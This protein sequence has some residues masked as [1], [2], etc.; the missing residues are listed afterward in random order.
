VYAISHFN[1]QR[2]DH[3]R[4]LFLFD[5]GL[6]ISAE[7]IQWLKVHLANCADFQ[8]ISK[9]PWSERITWADTNRERIESTARDPQATVTWW[10]E[11][12]AP[13]SLVAACIELAAA[14]EVGPSYI[15][16]LPVCL[17]GS[18]SGVQHLAMMMRDE[19]A[20]EHV[21]LV[22][23]DE[24]RDIYQ[25]ITDRVVERLKASGDEWADWWLWWT[26]IKRK[27]IKRPAMT[28][29]YSVTPYG[30]AQQ[31]IEAH[32]ELRADSNWPT[33]VAA[34]YLAKHIMAVSEE[35]L[36]RPAAAMKFI[37]KLA[38][39]CADK[40]KILEW[41]TPTGLPW[42]NRY[43]EPNVKTVHLELRDEYVRHRV[44]DGFKPDIQK[45]KAMDGAAP[46]FVHALDASHL[47]RVVNAAVL[48][49]TTSIAVVHDSFG[50]LAPR[51][52]GLHRIL[53]HQLA[54]LYERDVLA[55]LR[56]AAGSTE[57]LPAKGSLDPWVVMQS[58]YPFS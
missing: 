15:T 23:H 36:P 12:D 27:L 39:E 52:P 43:H 9:R 2:E 40:G 1:F 48:D 17:D 53:R 8:G 56:D 19:S 29:A 26:E 13:F 50:C 55:D 51:V 28:F 44:A 14:W 10:R 45:K 5:E 58:R 11:A 3:V 54:L 37:R 57:P 31:I 22:P 30:M 35:T 21:N 4:S 25:L 41:V 20:A 34:R 32:S 42:A 38:E 49:D 46:N 47:V 16:H 7:G 33:D 18:C 6:H 24:P